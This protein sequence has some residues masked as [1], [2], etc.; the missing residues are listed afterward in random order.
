MLGLFVDRHVSNLGG[1]MKRK[2]QGKPQQQQKTMHPIHME[3]RRYATKIG[4]SSDPL[5]SSKIDHERLCSAIR[6]DDA[7]NGAALR[8]LSMVEGYMR[9]QKKGEN[10]TLL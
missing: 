4:E 7:A 9:E 10:R 2:E 5:R 8:L 6:Q 3:Y 1:R